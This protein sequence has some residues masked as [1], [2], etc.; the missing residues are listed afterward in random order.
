MEYIVKI[1]KVIYEQKTM[2]LDDIIASR[3]KALRKQRGYSQEKV[4]KVLNVTRSSISNMEVSRHTITVEILEK[5]CNFYNVKS[6][7]ILPF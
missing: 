2:S 7:E 3:I 4:S 5:I 1:P 6:S